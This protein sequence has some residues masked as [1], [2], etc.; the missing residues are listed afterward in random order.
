LPACGCRY[1]VIGAAYF[2]PACGH[3]AA[4]HMFTQTI[5]GIR[6]SLNALDAVRA[7]IPDRD[8]A[9]ATSRLLVENSLQLA[10]TAFQ[11][12]AE[13]LYARLPSTS[14]AR[15]NAFQN[16]GD[17]DQLWQAAT[18]KAYSTHLTPEELAALQR[19]FQ[20]RHLLAHTQGIVDQDYIAKS[21]DAR[22]KI[23]Q[24]IVIRAD[25]VREALTHIEKLIAG[26][27]TDAASVIASPPSAGGQW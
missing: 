12:R 20:Q 26:L 25:A 8:T 22:Y 1:A 7:A 3:N 9:E 4:D 18:G 10:V 19:A 5:N 23:A 15:R 2:C 16:L 27:Q 11:R 24:R 14:K 6:G 21:G 13:T 17:G